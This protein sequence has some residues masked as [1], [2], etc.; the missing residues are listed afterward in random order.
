MA[1]K[2]PHDDPQT[3][4]DVE[5]PLASA[6]VHGVITSLSP[7]KKGRSANYFDA[8]LSDDTA[9]LRLVG[10]NASQQKTIKEFMNSK[11][12]IQFSDC[13]IKQARRGSKMEVMLKGSTQVKVSPKKFDP[14]AFNFDD[15]DSMEI[16]L[17]NLNSTNVFDR[18]TVSVKVLACTNALD[19]SG[20]KTKQ[21]ITV[22]DNTGVCK[23]TLWEENIGILDTNASYMLKNFLVKEYAT[24]KFLSMAKEGSE[25]HPISDIGKVK[26]SEEIT[27]HIETI[28]NAVII[29]VIQLDSYRSCLRCKARVEP[30]SPPL[31]RCS[32]QDCAML[33]LFDVCTQQVSVKVLCMSNSHM[34]SLYAYGQTVQDLACIDDNSI[35]TEEALLKSPKLKSLSFNANNI[36][37]GF[38]R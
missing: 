35:V 5:S 38:Q 19:V 1:R 30:C 3:L 10:F 31:G 36:I 28:V 8:T 21:D 22:A 33:Q 29:A 32:K 17:S 14:S 12:S 37:T 6:T 27:D 26:D 18:V 15:Y 4:N 2:R 13:Q 24:I 20:G 7:I 34:H 23:V 11:T 16:K 25:I 9:K